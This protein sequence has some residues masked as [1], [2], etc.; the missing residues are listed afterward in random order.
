MQSVEHDDF[1]FDFSDDDVVHSVDLNEQ[2]LTQ[3]LSNIG[4]MLRF[5][6]RGRTDYVGHI[7]ET[8]GQ[9]WMINP[10]EMVP[11]RNYGLDLI[12]R[13][14][15]EISEDEECTIM[16]NHD[17]FVRAYCEFNLTLAMINGL[18]L[19]LPSVEH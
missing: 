2:Q 5:V 16:G 15:F 7:V 10:H 14:S 13:D 11:S 12:S 4:P 1:D 9:M 18:P 6:R 17:D 8:A 19:L 3:A